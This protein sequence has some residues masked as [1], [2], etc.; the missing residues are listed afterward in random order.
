MNFKDSSGKV[1]FSYEGISYLCESLDH[2]NCGGFG[3]KCP[4]HQREGYG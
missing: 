2:S 4:C 1:H 3:C